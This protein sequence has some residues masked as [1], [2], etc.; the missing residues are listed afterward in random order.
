MS[1]WKDLFYFN[2]IE[3]SGIIV[4]V[5]LIFS[6]I[7]APKVIEALKVRQEN[8]FSEFLAAVKE[9]EQKRISGSAEDSYKMAESSHR[10]QAKTVMSL[11]QFDPNT[12][13]KE[14][15]IEMGFPERLSNTINNFRNAG[16]Q[17]NKKEDLKRIF[18]MTDYIYNQT[19]NYVVIEST[20]K[21]EASQSGNDTKQQDNKLLAEIKPATITDETTSKLKSYSFYDDL[22]ININTA[23]SLELTKLKGIGQVFSNRIVRYRD[24]LGG[25]YCTYQLMDVFG[26]DSTRFNNLKDNIYVD[27]SVSKININKAEFAD[28][29]RHPYINRNIANS[30]V[31]I[32]KQHGKY[33]H[34]EDIKKSDLIKEETFKKIKHYISV[35]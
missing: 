29:V 24:L 27:G 26:M 4:L 25:F 5:I 7:L 12:V 28:L 18:G 34:I 21:N 35:N 10:Q 32:R 6:V 19:K 23:D 11:R 31:M 3:R 17:F 13:S 9:F 16:G 14:E 22:N 15:L 33:S 30:I 8:D 1:N 20:A 2:K